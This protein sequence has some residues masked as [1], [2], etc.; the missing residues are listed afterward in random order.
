M[1]LLS[2]TILFFSYNYL[3]AAIIDEHQTILTIALPISCNS[4]SA[5]AFVALPWPCKFSSLLTPV[6]LC[7]ITFFGCKSCFP[8]H[9]SS[10]L[11]ETSLSLVAKSSK[12]SY[13]ALLIYANSLLN[14]TTL[15]DL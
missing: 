13:V 12:I 2:H 4:S 6:N 1:K 5:L 11:V 8:L 15:Q 7:I 9:L 14:L 10:T 3:S